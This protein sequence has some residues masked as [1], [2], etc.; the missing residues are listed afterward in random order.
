MGEFTFKARMSEKNKPPVMLIY[1]PSGVGKTSFAASAPNSI[2]LTTEDGQGELK[3]RT[4]KDGVFTSFEEFM[5]GLQYVKD[6]GSGIDTLV[7]DSIDHLEPLVWQKVCDELGC[8]S[9]ESPGFQKGYSDALNYWGEIINKILEIRNER[10]LT[11]IILAHDTIVKVKDPTAE[12]YD[13][14]AIKLHKKAAALVKESVDMI[15]LLRIPVTVDNKGKAT[16][17]PKP[18]LYCRPSATYEA[19]SR[20]K[21]MPS[22]IIIPLED[23]W[24][25]VSKYIPALRE[26]NEVTT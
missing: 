11:V 23:G 9:I 2:W 20:Y 1:G 26:G 22:K 15:G 14:H 12:A 24:S 18:T 13:A 10:N 25:K 7:I 19:K 21:E 17:S 6:R 8:K 16:S 5:A 3:I 4:I